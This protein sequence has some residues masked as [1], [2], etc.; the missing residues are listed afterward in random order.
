MIFRISIGC[1]LGS[2]VIFRDVNLLL[3]GNFFDQTGVYGFPEVACPPGCFVTDL[4]GQK[5]DR[6]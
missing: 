6:T 5:K 2:M 4:A 3:R 1:F